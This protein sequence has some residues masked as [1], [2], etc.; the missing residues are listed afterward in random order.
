MEAAV[1]VVVADCGVTGLT[2][3]AAVWAVGAVWA[4]WAVWADGAVFAVCVVGAVPGVA[5]EPAVTVVM[6]VPF[7]TAAGDGLAVDVAA[8]AAVDEAPSSPTWTASATTASDG[9]R[10]NVPWAA[11]TPAPRP[12]A[13]SAPVTIH[14]LRAFIVLL[15][16]SWFVIRVTVPGG[17]L[18]P[19][20]SQPPWP[21]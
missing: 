6:D 5:T 1:G 2:G 19:T 18:P 3:D 10:S 13:P 4:V 17:P 14:A 21:P 12:T 11:A 20:G 16:R 9:V 8:D 15:L 7:C